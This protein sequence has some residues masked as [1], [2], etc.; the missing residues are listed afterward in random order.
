MREILAH[1]VDLQVGA[2]LELERMA[3]RALTYTM[4]AGYTEDDLAA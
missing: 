4:E 2:R 1:R 3:A